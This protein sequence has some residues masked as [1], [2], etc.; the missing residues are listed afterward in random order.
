M[1]AKSSR[2]ARESQTITVMISDYCR[3]YHQ[4]DKLCSDCIRLTNYAVERLRACLFQEGKTTCV[5]CPVHCYKPNMRER[6]RSVMR[7]AGPRMIYRHPVL[8][9][10]HMIDGRR[11]EPIKNTNKAQ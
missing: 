7:Y 6:I 1:S 9:I 3:A 11:K 4:D 10:L 8:A 5:K 2:I